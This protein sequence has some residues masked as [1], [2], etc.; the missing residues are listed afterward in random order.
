MNCGWPSAPAHD[1]FIAPTGASPRSTISRAAMSSVR[2]KSF[3]V[4]MNALV[5]ST[6]K[7]S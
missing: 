1:D 7:A 6:S 5:P 3:L 2:K 4:A